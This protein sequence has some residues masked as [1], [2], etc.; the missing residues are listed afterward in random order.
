MKK[1]LIVAMMVLIAVLGVRWHE[2]NERQQEAAVLSAQIQ[3]ASR[4]AVEQLDLFRST[5]GVTYA[6]A[7]TLANDRIGQLDKLIEANL[8]AKEVRDKQAAEHV[9]NYMAAAQA[10]LRWSR[11]LILAK[12]ET[13]AAKNTMREALADM[14]AYVANPASESGRF[15]ADVASYSA[16]PAIRRSEKAVADAQA[17]V[18]ALGKSLSDMVALRA[19]RPPLIPEDAYIQDA[20]VKDIS[21]RIE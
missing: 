10:S 18:D 15:R 17:A 8:K 20:Q 19:K 5:R 9:R 11:A 1:V 12:A 3:E 7:L 13:A 2:K 6:E 14:E 21:I 4:F 16:S